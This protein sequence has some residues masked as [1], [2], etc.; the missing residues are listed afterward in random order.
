M[1]EINAVSGRQA[2]SIQCADAFLLPMPYGGML[3]NRHTMMKA[4][5]IVAPFD[6]PVPSFSLYVPDEC[7]ASRTK[8]GPYEPGADSQHLSMRI[9]LQERMQSSSTCEP[10]G[11]IP[12]S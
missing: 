11:G 10:C 5:L 1:G 12:S 6:P 7:H 2:A 9:R 4:D 3:S 8:T